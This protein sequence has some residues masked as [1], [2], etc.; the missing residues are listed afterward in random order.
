MG[1]IGAARGSAASE[2]RKRAALIRLGAQPA[3]ALTNPG[4]IAWRAPPRCPTVPAMNPDGAD[5]ER[6]KPE[7]LSF[8]QVRAELLA[9]VMANHPEFTLEEAERML[10]EAG[11]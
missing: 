11:F 8:A 1:F 2:Q 6:W 7:L 10:R 3:L 4:S 5:Y 9:I